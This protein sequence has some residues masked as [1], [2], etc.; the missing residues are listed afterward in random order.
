MIVPWRIVTAGRRELDGPAD[1]VLLGRMCAWAVLVRAA[2]YGLPLPALV[3]LVMPR[4]RPG[5]RDRRQEAKIAVLSRWAGRMARPGDGHCLERGLVACRFLVLGHAE[6]RL[7]IGFRAGEAALTGHA[8]VLLDG[9]IFGE[10]ATAVAEFTR[11]AIFQADGELVADRATA[12]V[13]S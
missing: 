5:I 9:E 13:A 3:R 11:T 10:P 7:A 1:L 8:W 12:T 4:P 2:K 6:P